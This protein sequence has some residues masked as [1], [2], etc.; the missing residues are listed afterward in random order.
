V[1]TYFDG[2][3]TT[4]SEKTWEASLLAAGAAIEAADTIM[5]G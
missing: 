5:S 1:L 3:D 4:M 2:Q